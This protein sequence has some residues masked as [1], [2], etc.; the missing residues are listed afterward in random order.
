MKERMILFLQLL[1]CEVQL[2]K[3]V[4]F[5]FYEPYPVSFRSCDGKAGLR[6]AGVHLAG[7]IIARTSS[8]VLVRAP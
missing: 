4:L 1:R 7:E 2:L 3:S 6:S 8:L 5:V